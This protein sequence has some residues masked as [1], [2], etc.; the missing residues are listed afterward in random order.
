MNLRLDN[1]RGTTLIEILVTL[2]IIAIGIFSV[3]QLFSGGFVVLKRGENTTFAAR[4][5]EKEFERLR[6][7]SDCLPLGITVLDGQPSTV[8]GLPLNHTNIYN[9]RQ[10]IG[11]TVKIPGPRL[12]AG[13]SGT[14]VGSVYQVAF[15]PVTGINAVYSS[16]LQRR[17]MDSSN[18]DNDPKYWLRP[19]Q[20]AIDYDEQKICFRAAPYLRQ[21]NLSYSVWI[22]DSKTKV[23]SLRTVNNEL[24]SVPANADWLEIK[25]GGQ[26]IS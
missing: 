10:I 3:V 18:S 14:V 26:S 1:K 25:A 19:T 17:V 7:R 15:A 2:V 21:F 12:S 22:K 6:S 20:Y 23:R 4:L 24:I 9:I 13:S 16:N 11:E 5:A 8:P